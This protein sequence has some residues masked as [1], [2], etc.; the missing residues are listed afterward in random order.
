MRDPVFEIGQ[1][2]V[3]FLVV[4]L[5]GSSKTI[6]EIMNYCYLWGCHFCIQVQLGNNACYG[7]F[8]HVYHHFY[9]VWKAMIP[10]FLNFTQRQVLTWHDMGVGMKP[11]LDTFVLL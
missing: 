7:Y 11:F 4:A 2:H 8:L 6:K 3:S 10:G 1:M 9:V 5:L